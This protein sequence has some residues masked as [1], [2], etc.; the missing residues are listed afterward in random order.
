MSI[1]LTLV[2]IIDGLNICLKLNEYSSISIS[3]KL[4]FE[5]FSI[6]QLILHEFDFDF[7]K[8][9]AAGVNLTAFLEN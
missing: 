2:N 5:H 9:S 6:L 1:L 3:S 8:K 7:W 4:W